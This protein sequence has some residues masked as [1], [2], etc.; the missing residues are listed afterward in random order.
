MEPTLPKLRML[1]T[2]PILKILPVLPIL[3][4]LPALPI[5]SKLPALKTPKI[6]K[7]LPILRMLPKLSWLLRLATLRDEAFTEG[8]FFPSSVPTS[9][10]LFIKITPSYLLTGYAI[11]LFHVNP[12]T[13]GTED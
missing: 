1:P 6:L 7:T 9:I 4:M 8:L 11:P 3:R 5:L 12:L 10:T 13:S 2:L